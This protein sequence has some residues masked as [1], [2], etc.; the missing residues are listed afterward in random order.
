M[1]SSV[2]GNPSVSLISTELSR[3]YLQ[4]VKRFR[5]VGAGSF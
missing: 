1:G 2:E 3:T 5:K 4:K